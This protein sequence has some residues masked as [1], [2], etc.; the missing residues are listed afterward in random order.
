VCSDQARFDPEAPQM[1]QA[2]DVFE[3]QNRGIKV[4]ITGAI[5][6]SR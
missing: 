3:Q 1:R 5:E 4:D 2:L 6:G